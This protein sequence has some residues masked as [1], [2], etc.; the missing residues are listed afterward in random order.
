MFHLGSS[1]RGFRLALSTLGATAGL[2]SS[3]LHGASGMTRSGMA[4][5]GRRPLDNR[6]AKASREVTGR[7]EVPVEALMT[8]T[9]S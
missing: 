8:G 7:V 2:S 5:S 3:A 4:D 9:P 6:G 1:D